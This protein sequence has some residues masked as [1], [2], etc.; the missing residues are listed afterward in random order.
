MT[1]CRPVA[2][3]TIVDVRLFLSLFL[4]TL[5]PIEYLSYVSFAYKYAGVWPRREPRHLWPTFLHHL[6]HS[7]CVLVSQPRSTS[8]SLVSTYLH[9]LD[10]LGRPTKTTAPS[11]TN[12]PRD[13]YDSGSHRLLTTVARARSALHL[14]HSLARSRIL[15]ERSLHFI[16][17]LPSFHSNSHVDL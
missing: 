7:V 10:L 5:L 4:F 12:P 1:P 9:S 17:F 15:W 13:P 14:A 3:S 11:S 6:F 16:I 8:R 2:G